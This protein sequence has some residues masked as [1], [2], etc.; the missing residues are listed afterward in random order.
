MVEAGLDA[1]VEQV[2]SFAVRTE[3]A[4]AAAKAAP[5]RGGAGGKA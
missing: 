5:K 4:K 2:R 1:L 3:M